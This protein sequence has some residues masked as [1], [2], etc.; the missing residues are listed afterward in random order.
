MIGKRQ[1]DISGSLDEI[2]TPFWQ[3]GWALGALSGDVMSGTV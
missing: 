2:L 1:K 3:L